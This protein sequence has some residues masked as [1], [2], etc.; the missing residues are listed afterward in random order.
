MRKL[1]RQ[2]INAL[3]AAR[4]I[5]VL[6]TVDAFTREGGLLSLGTSYQHI[7]RR[8]A[9]YVDKIL[10]GTKPSD[11]PIERPTVFNMMINLR[12]A[13]LLGIEVP[14]ALLARADEVIE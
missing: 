7:Y 6:S 2:R 4:R 1:N 13:K 5:P 8:A 12:A 14:L 10:K 11:L 9:V 3:A